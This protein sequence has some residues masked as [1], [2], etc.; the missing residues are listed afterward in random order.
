MRDIEKRFYQGKLA[1]T[2]SARNSVKSILGWDAARYS[3]YFKN[4][5]RQERT[6]SLDNYRH[7]CANMQHE[8]GQW[9]S[10]LMLEWGSV[11]EKS[12]L[13]SAYSEGMVPLQVK[14]LA[15][16]RMKYL[17][18][19]FECLPK[20]EKEAFGEFLSPTYL[21]TG[22]LPDIGGAYTLYKFQDLY[23]LAV[24]QFEEYA[25]AVPMNRRLE[26]ARLVPFLSG[27]QI[28]NFLNKTIGEEGGNQ[29]SLFARLML[30]TSVNRCLLEGA[31]YE[32]LNTK[33]SELLK[34]LLS[35]LAMEFGERL[36]EVFDEDS[37][38]SVVARA[39]SKPATENWRPFKGNALSRVIERA[40]IVAKIDPALRLPKDDV[41]VC[42][43]ALLLGALAVAW[44]YCTYDK[45]DTRIIGVTHREHQVINGRDPEI[46]DDYSPSLRA[47]HRRQFWLLWNSFQIEKLS[48]ENLRSAHIQTMSQNFLFG[49]LI[50]KLKTRSVSDWVRLDVALSEELK[51]SGWDALPPFVS[52]Q[53]LPHCPLLPNRQA[54]F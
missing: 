43:S 1:E 30:N 28:E 42:P 32:R 3:I 6:K 51:G 36:P 20:S 39:M 40:K 9:A 23:G 22:A 19:V 26:A 7:I 35:Q 41:E 49:N 24:D 10:N 16:L 25:R 18:L 48:L 15:E 50:S 45:H 14:T 33:A 4:L 8:Y 52:N 34:G 44:S 11:K 37:I 21:Q 17:E 31:E 5:G 2:R 46:P 54:V 13:Q 53:S 47:Y 12:N 38:R 27:V 29:D